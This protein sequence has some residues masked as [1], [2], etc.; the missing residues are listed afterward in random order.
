MSSAMMATLQTAMAAGR[1][2]FQNLFGRSTSDA[3]PVLKV[4]QIKLGTTRPAPTPSA[5]NNRDKHFSAKN[6]YIPKSSVDLIGAF[7]A[8]HG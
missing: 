5:T 8:V 4:K 7:I 1:L 6:G 2:L 3:S